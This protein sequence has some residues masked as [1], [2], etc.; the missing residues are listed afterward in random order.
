[1]RP[2]RT[3][4]LEPPPTG[5][6]VPANVV[7]ALTAAGL[8]MQGLADALGVSVALVSLWCADRRRPTLAAALRIC[9]LTGWRLV[10]F[11][12]APQLPSLAHDAAPPPQ[13]A[14]RHRIDWPA[15]EEALRKAALLDAPPSLTSILAPFGVDRRR[16]REQLPEVT[17]AIRDRHRATRDAAV[18]RRRRQA[19][20]AI[21]DATASVHARGLYPGRA[22]VEKVLPAGVAFRGREARDIWKDELRRRG[23][24]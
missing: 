15:V 9:R 18:A 2:A 13:L 17:A 3:A 5:A 12:T 1:M 7:A 10:D 21:R 8:T 16:A 4:G 14:T 24:L 6:A 11:L 23:L 22:Q 19:D 20:A